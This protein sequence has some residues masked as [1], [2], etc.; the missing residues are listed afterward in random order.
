MIHSYE[1]FS[2]LFALPSVNKRILK[3]GNAIE[4]DTIKPAFLRPIPEYIFLDH[5]V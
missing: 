5:S 4:I 2:K 3:N 1:I